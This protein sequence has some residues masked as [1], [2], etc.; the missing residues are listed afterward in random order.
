MEIDGMGVTVADLSGDGAL[1][2]YLSDLGGNEL[3]VRDGTRFVSRLD[4][5]AARV[6]PPGAGDSVVSSSWA[7]AAIDINTDGILDIVVVNGGMPFGPVQNKIHGTRIE[8]DDPPAILLGLGGGRYTDGWPS[9]AIEWLG[10]GRGLAVGDID[11]DGDTDLV[12][13]R[14]DASPV[15]LLN[16]STGGT[17]TVRPAGGCSPEGALVTVVTY[18]GTVTQLLGSASFGG[19]HAPG[20]S[21]GQPVVGSPLTITWPGNHKVVQAVPAG[22]RS[23]LT[24]EC[25]T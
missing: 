13:T 17:V 6:R 14:L 16:N 15:V 25:T 18:E 8:L 19:M 7:S 20:A 1:D 3:L 23:T 24:V 2:G 21:I 5:G 11:N 22:D 12:I 4:S 9:D 10:A